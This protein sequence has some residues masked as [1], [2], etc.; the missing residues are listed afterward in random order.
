VNAV[1]AAA[2]DEIR[3]TVADAVGG[4][5]AVT[6]VHELHPPR[7]LPFARRGARWELDFAR[8]EADRLEYLLRVRYPDGREE[9]TTDPGNPL[10]APGPFGDKSVLELP[11][12][13]PPAWVADDASPQGDLRELELATRVLKTSVPALLWSPAGLAPDASEPLLLVHD[14][15]EFAKYSD[16][17]RLFDH[18][19][20]AAEVPPFRAALLPP[21]LDRNETYSASRRYARAV[22]EDWAPALAEAAPHPGR[23][24]A[25]GA[26][27]GALSFLH[28]HFAQPGLFAG[29]FLQSGSYFRRRLDAHESD[30]GRFDRIARFVSTVVGGRSGAERIPVTLTCGTAE[31]NIHNNH[32][33][34]ASLLKQGWDVHMVEHRDAHNWIAWR[35]AL[36]PHL[37]DLL[38]RAAR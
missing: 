6:L 19:V 7:E 28:A 34:A 18:M 1:P 20:G 9:W 10:R 14:G 38:L 32:V 11:G 35:D 5:R 31:E 30:F 8:P 16:L 15:P 25:L 3:L 36:H 26:S 37:A 21:P 29:L 27:L 17:L 22:A 33:V 2:D 12:Y 13:E 24:A 23:V 4:Y